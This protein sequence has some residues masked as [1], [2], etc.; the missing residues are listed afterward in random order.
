MIASAYFSHKELHGMK[1][2]N[3]KV[4]LETK[5][6]VFDELPTVR[7]RGTCAI[8]T[9]LEGRNKWVI[10]EDIPAFTQDRDYIEKLLK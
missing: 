3:K 7:K 1:S 4:M 9:Q 2:D 10:D 5:G 6:V 8:K